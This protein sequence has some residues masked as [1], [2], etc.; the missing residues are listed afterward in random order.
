MENKKYD[1]IVIGAGISG[2]LTANLLAHK[3]KKVLV[4]EKNNY[5]G[6][7]FARFKPAD[8]EMDYA[9]SYFLGV[10]DNSTLSRFLKD[11]QLP[12]SL[13][14]VKVPVAD[15]YIFPDLEFEL[16]SDYDSLKGDLCALFPHE[17]KGVGTFFDVLKYV[18]YSFLKLKSSKAMS[19]DVL[20]RP[21][22]MK[23]YAVY[24]D[25]LFTD[26]RLKAILS[27]RVFGSNVSMITMVSYLGKLIFEGLFQEK[28]NQSITRALTNSLQ[29]M[30][31]D[32]VYNSLVES[33]I[34]ED[35]YCKSVIA[36]NLEYEADF[37]I[38]TCDMT[39]MFCSMITPQAPDKIRERLQNRPKSLSSISLYLVMSSLPG[40]IKNIQASRIYLFSDYDI[41]ENYKRKE[42]GILDVQNGIKINIQNIMDP[43]FKHKT[44]YV[45]RAEID[46][47]YITPIIAGDKENITQQIIG[48]LEDRLQINRKY[49][50][51]STIFFP[52]DFA[53]MTLS[54]MG[55]ASGWAPD[56]SFT[57]FS[58]F[59]TGIAHNFFQ[60]GCW[61]KYGSGIFPIF[62]SAKEA[63]NKLIKEKLTINY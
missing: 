33:V 23:S 4:L 59:Q 27:A 3:G 30:G 25:D 54:S 43:D 62:L 12:D 13:E 20:M 53:R 51:E 19:E 22:L 15:H 7:Y 14:F 26:K 28:N 17:A 44:A 36:D 8:Y 16:K 58:N 42:Q 56:S 1:C 41:V 55:A 38:S 63:V 57:D 2:L 45:M 47:S 52:E 37:V 60:V 49:I 29:A 9:V 31:A 46:T 61:D 6:G 35:N 40:K 18:Y 21:Y 32:I 24:L 11:I 34:V 48:V 10:E 5:A 39:N 50:L